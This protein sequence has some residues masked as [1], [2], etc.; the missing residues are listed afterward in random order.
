MLN[1]DNDYNNDNDRSNRMMIIIILSLCSAMLRFPGS[2][3]WQL[4]AP[5]TTTRLLVQVGLYDCTYDL[6]AAIV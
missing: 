2:N 4:R 5:R 3:L 1:I 6:S